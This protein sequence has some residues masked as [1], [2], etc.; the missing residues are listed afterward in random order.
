MDTS[1]Q[2]AWWT[3][4]SNDT[5]Y[6]SSPKF[7]ADIHALAIAVIE[8]A[9]TKALE[10]PDDVAAS[11]CLFFTSVFIYLASGLLKLNCLTSVSHSCIT[12]VSYIVCTKSQ[13]YSILRR[14]ESLCK[15]E[16]MQVSITLSGFV[17][18]V[19]ADVANSI[20]GPPLY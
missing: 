7:L 13:I 19:V 5:L 20:H 10:L 17:S 6:A 1:L 18:L 11:S 16:S 3:V 12:L 9:E 2:I 15:S 8:D 4:E 14:S